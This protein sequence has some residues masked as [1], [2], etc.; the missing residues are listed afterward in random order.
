[1]SVQS[2]VGKGIKSCQGLLDKISEYNFTF[3]QMNNLDLE[4]DCW[5]FLKKVLYIEDVGR[6]KR[7]G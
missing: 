4:C 3:C 5:I 7:C 6:Q 1:M 2:V